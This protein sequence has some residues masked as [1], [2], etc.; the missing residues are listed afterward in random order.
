M[1]T[2]SLSMENESLIQEYLDLAAHDSENLERTMN[3]LT[4]DCVWVMEPTG[5]VFQGKDELRAFVR[6]AMGGR[7]HQGEYQV[8]ISSWFTDGEYLC[9]EYTHGSILSGAYSAGLKPAIKPGILRYCLTFHM[10]QGKFDQVHEYINV[11][12]FIPGLA[13]PLGL[14]FLKRLVNKGQ[15]N[16]GQVAVRPLSL[17]IIGIFMLLAGLAEV[18]TGFTHNFFGITTSGLDVFTISSTAIGLFYAAAG[19]LILTMKRWAAALAL[20]LLGADILGRVMLVAAGLYP[21]DTARNT[22]AMIAGTVIAA[23][24]ALY[25]GWKWKSFR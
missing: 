18:I 3:I 11:T 4:D 2:K 24:I 9:V 22:F 17:T 8:E 7:T 14:K 10:R 1:E 15:A 19:L 20:A 16:P 23:L 12:S 21:M 25:I 6:T 13:L 5:D